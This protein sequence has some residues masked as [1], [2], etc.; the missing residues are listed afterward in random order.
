MNIIGGTI[1]LLL[2]SLSSTAMGGIW[3]LEINYQLNGLSKTGFVRADYWADDFDQYIGRDSLFELAFEEHFG[4]IDQID[5]YDELLDREKIASIAS[6]PM[7]PF[8]ILEESKRTVS[9]QD[10]K[11]L[12]LIKVWKKN[13]YWIDV[14][15]PIT[16]LDITWI[17]GKTTIE[18]PIGNDVGCRLEVHNFG[19]KQDHKKLLNDFVN[20]YSIKE[21]DPNS[22][23]KKGSLLLQRLKKKKIV[24]VELCGC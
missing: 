4:S 7:H 24:I 23:D 12:S 13:D 22:Y 19:S 1:V 6:F 20:L 10:L 21:N 15:T 14:L 17:S 16:E 2:W 8:Q 9:R 11:H 18:H 3:L 5:I